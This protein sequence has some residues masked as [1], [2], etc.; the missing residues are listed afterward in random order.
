M[1]ISWIV[2]VT[3]AWPGTTYTCPLVRR[4]RTCSLL[5]LT[6]SLTPIVI[7]D[8]EA[9]IDVAFNFVHRWNHHL[10][11]IPEA[12]YCCLLGALLRSR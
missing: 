9:A 4:Q 7:A 5:T 12:R 3:H 11:Q 1:S 6:R 2:T 8:G 10:L